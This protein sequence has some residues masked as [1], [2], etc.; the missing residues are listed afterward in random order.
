MRTLIE[1]RHRAVVLMTVLM[2]F[3]GLYSNAEA[4][5]VQRFNTITTGAITFTG[6][7]LGLSKGTSVNAP[8]TNGS[9]GTFIT[10]D[11]SFKDNT[12]PAGTTEDWTKNSSQA[13]LNIPAGATVLYAELIWGGS[14]RWG[15]EDVFASLGTSVKLTRPNGT[16]TTV[17]PAAAT[18]NNL[19][20]VVGSGCT[21]SC[22][23]T[24]SA[25]VT[26]LIQAGGAG[27][28]VVGGVPG[29]QT[30]SENNSNA[31][32]WTL[33]VVY[34]KSGLPARNLTLFTGAELTNQTNQPQ[35]TVSGFCTPLSGVRKGRLMVTAIE[36]DA[37][38][39][40]AACR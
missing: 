30:T 37:G 24:R 5:Y 32:G 38:L 19:G 28:Y 3:L 10:T 7:T 11:T 39:G 14:Y 35:A 17:A 23:Y 13:T 16:T 34:E 33:A 9:I 1:F 26:S 36:G 22:F 27:N 18:A 25:N 29:T 12:Y 20:N 15:A 6:N 2:A 21:A 40:G 8:G 31:A 4:A